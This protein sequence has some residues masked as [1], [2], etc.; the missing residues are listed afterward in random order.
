VVLTPT[1]REILAVA[2]LA[3]WGDSRG[4]KDDLPVDRCRS[5]S[6]TDASRPVIGVCLSM[7]KLLRNGGGLLAAAV[8][9]LGVGA[10]SKASTDTTSVA[11]QPTGVAGTTSSAA[12]GSLSAGSAG[13]DSAS[14][15]SSTGS[16]SASPVDAQ[17]C[18]K[19]RFALH[20]GLGA[21]AVHHWIWKPYQAGGFASAASGRKAA[22]VKAGVAGLFA[23][24]EFKVALKDLQGCQ[25][26]QGLTNALQAG[27]DKVTGAATALKG[28][29]VDTK[30]LTDLNTSLGGIENT[31]KT[32][33]IT[34]TEQDPSAVQLATGKTGN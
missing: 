25:G 27:V 24:H 13:S 16:V 15:T 10:C 18:K 32:D 3:P 19:V 7:K 34:V 20:A 14:A 28:G 30:S 8:L 5:A 12:A 6:M 33:G 22:F 29:T 21:G 2:G 1:L 31:A 9:V 26:L 4:M 11:G 23:L 17:S